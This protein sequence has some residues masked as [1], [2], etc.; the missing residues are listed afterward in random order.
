MSARRVNFWLLV[1]IAVMAVG[2]LAWAAGIPLMETKEQL[3]LAY[4]LSAP[5]KDG[6]VTVTLTVTDFGKLEPLQAV[7]LAIPG[8]PKDGGRFD[9]YLPMA[10]KCE[11]GKLTA[12]AQLSR[13]L[14]E[15]ATVQLVPEN[16]PDGGQVYGWVFHPIPVR[17]HIKDAP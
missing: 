10:T 6:S 7:I 4:E 8:G 1:G 14:A 15:R 16:P 13:E 9:V 5:A 12:W 11:G 17:E 2:G 3:G